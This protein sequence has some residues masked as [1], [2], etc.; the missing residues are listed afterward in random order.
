MVDTIRIEPKSKPK[1]EAE[2]HLLKVY[3][4]S[5]PDG[6]PTRADWTRVRAGLVVG[7]EPPDAD[8]F[9]VCDVTMSRRHFRIGMTPQGPVL[10]DLGSAN[11]VWVNEQRVITSRLVPGD[12]IRAG[13]SLLLVC[14]RELP[15]LDRS[16]LGEMVVVSPAMV[17]IVTHLQAI[18]RT[19]VPVFLVGETGV[20]KDVLA[21]RIHQWSGR[22]GEFHAV[23]CA[24]IT[25][26]LA[27]SSLFGSER[28]SFTGSTRSERGWF[29]QADG[30]T[31]LLDELGEMP[32][33][34]QVKLNR[35]LE[36]GIVTPVGTTD[37]QIVD[38]RVLAATNRL[39]AAHG[40]EGFREDLLARL[41]DEVIKVPPLRE[42]KEEIVPLILSVAAKDERGAECLSTEFVARAM[43]YGWPRNVRQLTKMVA[44]A[45]RRLPQGAALDESHF[46][47]KADILSSEVE[48]T[49]AAV[50][51]AEGCVPKA[52]G[53][54][55]L[56][57][58]LDRAGGNVS[59]AARLLGINRRRMYRLLHAKGIPVRSA[60]GE[61]AEQ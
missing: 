6:I 5:T 9:E 37:S 42:R 19:K 11:G 28:G 39:G 55:E 34:L 10:D 7:R 59:L 14:G 58:A 31:L 25:D 21:H 36:S 44:A 57:G 35:V 18:A 60:Q 40:G 49:A 56:R 4:P 23:N 50:R 47:A 32:P 1:H 2:F 3:P 24:A 43:L 38:V 15:E 53:D 48:S 22:Q 30:G 61:G 46:D 17:D 26:T 41:E 52:F 16:Q 29:R 20:G 33:Y 27:E 12:V 8:R 54:E 13:R 45:L 51:A